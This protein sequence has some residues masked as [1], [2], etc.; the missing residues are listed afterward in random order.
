M[1][2]HS[3]ENVAKNAVIVSQKICGG[4]DPWKVTRDHAI[5][6]LLKMSNVRRSRPC[7]VVSNNYFPYCGVMAF[8]S[9][10]LHMG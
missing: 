5:V 8:F 7:K 4:A 1:E 3:D 2:R 9:V 6:L 10:G